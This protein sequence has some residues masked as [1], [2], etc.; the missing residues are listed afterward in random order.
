M[1]NEN[2]RNFCIATCMLL[3]FLLWTVAIQ[4]V[5]VQAIGPQESSVGFA[6]V[7]RFVHNLTG[8]HMSLYTITDWLGLV[9][10]MFVMG[11][12][13]FGLIQWIQ[14]KHLLKVDYSILVLGGFYIV[15]MAVYVLFEMLVVNYRP[16]M[17]DG[18]LESSY[19]SSTTMLVMCVMPTAVMQ[20]NARIRNDIL[21]RCVS[22]AIV[23][24]IVFMVIGR[25]V[26]GVHWITDIV[27]GA[28]LSA[29][30][31]LMYRTIIRLEVR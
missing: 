21:K 24:F 18:I 17:I 31:V 26:S 12:G 23:A 28:L 11:F 19:P 4:F 1:K 22:S 10:L 8:V 3:A 27:G 14:R 16:V 6:T 13:T 5:D 7:N 29:G 2:Q 25:L 9:P 30:L 15:V 20:F